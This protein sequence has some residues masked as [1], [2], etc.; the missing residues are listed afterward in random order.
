MKMRDTRCEPK[1]PLA[2]ECGSRFSARRWPRAFALAG[3]GGAGEQANKMT[4]F[5]TTESA[6][7][8]AELFSLPADQMSHIQILHRRS[9]AARAHAAPFRRGGVQRLSRPRR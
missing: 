5:S 6:A 2:G 8:K 7:S 4:S 3:C 1:Q 9:G